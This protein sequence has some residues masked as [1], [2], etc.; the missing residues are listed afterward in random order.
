MRGVNGESRAMNNTLETIHA[1]A[2][3]IASAENR[4]QQ[5]TFQKRR[6]GG[7]WSIYWCFGSYKQKKRIE[8]SVLVSE[9]SASGTNVPAAENRTQ[10][11]AMA[12]P[13]V[14]PPSS[15]ASFIQSEPPSA[16]QSPAGLVS[17]TSISASMYSPGPASIFAIGPYA[18]ET[19]LVSPPVFSTFSTEPSTA[20]FTPPPESVHLTTPSSPEV[21]FAQFLGP[22]LQY[23]EAGQRFPISHYE[24]QSYQLHPGSPVGQL[25][26]PSSGISG[27][28]TS[29][30]F[31]DG[32][33]AA[34]LRFPEFRMGDP[35]KLLNLD[36]LS[37]REWGLH[38]GS[39][40]LTPDAT[41]STPRNGFLLDHQISEIASHVLVD[42][43]KQTDPVAVNHRVS[44]EL[45]TEEVEGCV[46]TETATLSKSMSGSLQNEA[47]REKVESATKVVD[48]YECRVG[49]TSNE[50][51]EKAPADREAKPQYHKNQSITLGS[52]KEFNFD[53]VDG[54]DAHK[55]IV[56]SDW[57]ANEKV[58]GKDDGIPRNWS[59]FPMMQPGVS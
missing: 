13:F 37:I 29:S 23:G 22:N 14:A 3:A 54:A 11:P 12:L 30:P 57:W 45:T 36:K 39:G 5:A 26:S 59:F 51:P 49:E 43:G 21:P 53:N 27:S 15:P 38:H 20:P 2:N 40:T 4:V 18:H 16:T 58:A 25:I 1:A 44:F 32:E 55:P 52:A 42:R 7:F 47:T 10:A 28:G 24:F 35:P 9:T 17:L 34:A 33:F 41:R 50:R 31:P 48:D 19:Q 56:S 46:E 6:W 8:P